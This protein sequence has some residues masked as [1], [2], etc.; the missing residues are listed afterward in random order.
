MNSPVVDRIE[1]HSYKDDMHQEKRENAASAPENTA[2]KAVEEANEDMEH[3]EAS[4]TAEGL[5]TPVKRRRGNSI[6]S[7][8][9]SASTSPPSHGVSSPASIA[10]DS[11]ALAVQDRELDAIKGA[12]QLAIQRFVTAEGKAKASASAPSAK[13]ARKGKNKKK[14]TL[15]VA[16]PTAVTDSLEDVAQCINRLQDKIATD[17]FDL[18][19]LRDISH[20]SLVF[21]RAVVDS[22]PLVPSQAEGGGVSAVLSTLPSKPVHLQL[23][24]TV[25]HAVTSVPAE[26]T[27]E[28]LSEVVE[29]AASSADEQSTPDWCWLFVFIAQL[30]TPSVVK[31]LI[32]RSMQASR[33]CDQRL[34][35]DVLDHL[36]IRQSADIVAGITKTLNRLVSGEM[37][38]CSADAAVLRLLNLVASSPSLVS[39]VDDSFHWI[40]TKHL[41]VA[42]WDRA[43]NASANLSTNGD[44]AQTSLFSLLLK[45]IDENADKLPNASLQTLLV[46]QQ[47]IGEEDES[48]S[49]ELVKVASKFHAEMVRIAQNQSPLSLLRNIHRKLPYIVHLIMEELARQA[50]Q[51]GDGLHEENLPVIEGWTQWMAAIASLISRRDVIDHILH[52]DL[53]QCEASEP[54]IPANAIA[55]LLSAI[56]EPGS[57]DH[58]DMLREISK[59]LQHASASENSQH[60]LLAVLDHLIERS[61]D[62]TA[63]TLQLTPLEIDTEPGA[64]SVEELVG[65]FSRMS[66]WQESWSQLATWRGT[67]GADLWEYLLDLV[68]VGEGLTRTELTSHALQLLAKTPF[69]SLEDPMWQFRCLRKLTTVYFYALKQYR[70]AVI[71]LEA[72]VELASE[73][74]HHLEA[75]RVVIGR[76]MAFDGAVAHYA[77]SVSTQFTALW[78]DALFSTALA[79]TVPTHFPSSRKGDPVPS[80]RSLTS[81]DNVVIRSE[82]TISSK[83][84]N[85]QSSQVITNH[86][87]TRLVYRKALDDTWE[88]EMHAAQ[89]CSLLATNVLAELVN[90]SAPLSLAADRLEEDRLERRLK[91][92]VDMLLERAIPCC[93]VPSDDVYK[94]FLPNRSSFDMDL[95]IEQWL[96]HFPGFLKL[97]RTVVE[98]TC[99]LPGSTQSLRLIPLVKSAL[100]VLLGH[101]N[102]VKGELEFQNTD[103]PPYMRNRNQLEMSCEIVWILRTARWLPEPLARTA[104]LLPLTTP[105]DIRAILFSCWFFLADNPPPTALPSTSGGAAAKMPIE[106]YLLPIRKAL[107]HNIHKIG[108]RYSMFMC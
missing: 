97:L 53:M 17:L 84:T 108:A 96:N 8:V 71:D 42:L 14:P 92:I 34:A 88:R 82:R 32:E 87:E 29:W 31:L 61:A 67:S 44:G 83:C 90:S 33:S 30:D 105:A 70:A 56:V 19:A 80:T 106:F 16:S 95:R 40:V 25:R 75:L 64:G 103:V 72:P 23:A 5:T 26:S 91:M 73:W 100:V 55:E 58:V 6:A 63:S 27:V 65:A 85:L 7:D 79:T 59:R 52:A 49:R 48:I 46:I 104:E 60:R 94:E 1:P 57:A 76:V 93:G 12:L 24:S 35:V 69:P 77:T 13:R 9:S 36:S 107:H 78:L 39:A 68:L 10:I 15:T 54:R 45:V 28:L 86:S 37:D 20:I 101:W 2:M 3:G 98:A 89:T 11:A 21:L 41:V 43:M 47:V 66:P 51:D 102:S 50:I 18:P 62:H 81:T 38:G 4:T 74:L 99:A 22:D